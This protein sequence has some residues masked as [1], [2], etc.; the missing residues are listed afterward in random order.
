MC[1]RETVEE[2][3]KPFPR[4]KSDIP[5][6]LFEVGSKHYNV[7]KSYIVDGI[8]DVGELS[9][10]SGLAEKTVYNVKSQVNGVIRE[11]LDRKGMLNEKGPGNG[12]R[13]RESGT[14]IR[15]LG[16]SRWRYCCI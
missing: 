12:D 8:A 9:K 4:M 6:Y 16:T 14:R 10:Q 5:G 7:S 3:E 2:E 11:F 13:E 1:A 15:T